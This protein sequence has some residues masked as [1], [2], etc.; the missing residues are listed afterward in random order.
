MKK[1]FLYRFS[2]ILV[3]YV[4]LGAVVIGSLASAGQLPSWKLWTFLG[5]FLGAFALTVGI[6]EYVIYRKKK[7]G[8]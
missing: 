8:E 4:F 5:V 3:A 1:G 6:N 7:N 2:V